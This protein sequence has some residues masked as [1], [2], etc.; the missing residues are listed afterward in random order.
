M[1]F[2][3]ISVPV[4][5]NIVPVVGIGDLFILGGIYFS[6]KKLNYSDWESILVPMSGLLLALIVGLLF[7]GVFAIPFIALTVTLYIVYKKRRNRRGS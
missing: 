5:G 2:L 4:Q 1:R 7:G 6:L 3:T